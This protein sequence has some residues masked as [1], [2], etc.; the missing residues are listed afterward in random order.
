MVNP[1]NKVELLNLKPPVKKSR[2][3]EVEIKSLVDTN[4]LIFGHSQAGKLGKSLSKKAKD[5]GAKITKIVKVGYSDGRDHA[6]KKGL[7]HVLDKI[8]NKGF[9]HAYLFLGG[10]TGSRG[11]DYQQAKRKIINHMINALKI[12][13]ERIL[14]VLPP[15]NMD[16]NYSKS[17]L[18]LNQRAEEFFNSLSVKVHPQITGSADDFT[19]DG[20][21]IKSS[22]EVT[23]GVTDTMLRSFVTAVHSPV[24]YKGKTEGGWTDYSKSKPDD[25]RALAQIIIQEALKAGLDPL[26]ALNKARVE[27]FNPNSAP[28][29]KKDRKGQVEGV[30]YGKGAKRGFHGIF[31]FKGTPRYVKNWEE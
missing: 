13:K 16:N 31:Q 12:P 11:P 8:P 30:D 19:E 5:A 6:D 28:K 27:G 18:S 24:S 17:R 9:S 3:R 23:S 15:I 14:V 4:I 25:R 20:I 26:F 2:P 29:K 22:G 21:H 1:S 7:I 10:N